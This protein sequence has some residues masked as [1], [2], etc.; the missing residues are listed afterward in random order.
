[1]GGGRSRR[2]NVWKK[3][4]PPTKVED[5]LDEL[6]ELVFLRLISPIDIVRAAFTCR[7]WHQVIAADGFRALGSVH[8]AP[9]YHVIGHFHVD[10][11][12]HATRPPGRKPFFVPSSS[13]WADIVAARNLTLD[14][15]PRTEYGD[16]NWELTDVRGGLLLLFEPL[17]QPQPRLIIC[18]LLAQR[19]KAIPPSA[20]FHGCEFLGAFLLHGE[21]AGSPISLSNFKVTC[22][23]IARACA[24]SS[25][26]GG[27]WTSGNT[28]VCGNEYWL[29]SGFDMRFAGCGEDGSVAYWTIGKKRI[30][31]AL[32]KDAA[33]LSSSVM[34]DEVEYDALR[35]KRHG[36]EY[37]Y[38]LPWPPTIRACLS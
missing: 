36:P 33:E 4:A 31:L 13:P 8:G 19:F 16:F 2:K 34:P 5:V 6:L 30:L 27:R 3:A 26:G 18:D 25:V 11:C 38:D 7:R 28:A 12:Q 23:A 20:W 21:D 32:D 29:A 22:A 10:E 35:E 14:F 15:L 1:M 24:F 9:S 17:P 37:V